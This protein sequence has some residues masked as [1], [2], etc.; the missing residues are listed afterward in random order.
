MGRSGFKHTSVWHG[1]F[2]R[3]LLSMCLAAW[4]AKSSANSLASRGRARHLEAEKYCEAVCCMCSKSS[5]KSTRRNRQESDKNLMTGRM[6]PWIM[7]WLRNKSRCCSSPW[8]RATMSSTKCLHAL[9]SAT[10]LS[11]HLARPM[12]LQQYN[13]TESGYTR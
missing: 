7:V 6:S 5:T 2:W 9:T 11:L 8:A 12:D 10:T 4:P 1:L 3:Y 13:W